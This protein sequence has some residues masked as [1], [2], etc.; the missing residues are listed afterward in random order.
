MCWL[1]A[2]FG[3]GLVLAAAHGEG[4]GSSR[5]T[6]WQRRQDNNR[7]GRPEAESTSEARCKHAASLRPN[8]LF[9]LK[10]ISGSNIYKKWHIIVYSDNSFFYHFLMLLLYTRVYL[11]LITYNTRPTS[12]QFMCPKTNLIGTDC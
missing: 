10:I 2:R 5:L 9:S 1:G 3:L 11:T 8:T 7:V 4:K 12:A 6:G